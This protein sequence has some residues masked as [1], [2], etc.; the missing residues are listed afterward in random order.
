MKTKDAFYN[1]TPEFVKWVNR[2]IEETLSKPLNDIIL[3]AYEEEVD[4]DHL[5]DYIKQS[6]SMYSTMFKMRTQSEFLRQPSTT[7]GEKERI[8]IAAHEAWKK[9]L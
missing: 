6:I 3:K 7:L 2:E 4:L 1:N 9:G 5:M 8:V